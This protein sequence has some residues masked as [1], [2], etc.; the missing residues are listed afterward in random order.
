MKHIIYHILA[1]FFVLW[2][3]INVYAQDSI[4]YFDPA[5]VLEVEDD[6]VEI[7]RL[8]ACQVVAGEWQYSKPY[9][10]AQ[11]KYSHKYHFYINL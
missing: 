9:V 6:T 7:A 8:A 11:R 5:Q 3:S 1:L 4:A 2:L 10:H